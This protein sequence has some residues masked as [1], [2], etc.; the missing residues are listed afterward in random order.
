MSPNGHIIRDMQYV[1]KIKC[2]VVMLIDNL[3]YSTATKYVCVFFLHS[4]KHSLKIVL[5]V[6]EGITRMKYH[7]STVTDVRA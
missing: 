2:T 4:C 7:M 1:I 5:L 6:W 3:Y